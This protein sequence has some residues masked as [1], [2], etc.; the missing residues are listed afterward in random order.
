VKKSFHPIAWLLPGEAGLISP[1]YTLLI[2]S[3][4]AGLTFILPFFFENVQGRSTDI[5]GLLLAIPS[6]A[7]IVVGPISG[8]LSDRYGTRLPMICAATITTLSLYLLAHFTPGTSLIFAIGTILFLGIGI[9]IYFP[10][11]MSQILGAAPRDCEGVASG[12]MIT[13]RYIGGMVGIAIFGTVATAVPAGIAAG[14]H[15]L[16]LPPAVLSEG[17]TAAFTLGM[18]FCIVAAVISAAISD[19]RKS[20]NKESPQ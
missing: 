2:T 17:Y 18:I 7:I 9:G 16:S 10:S 11:N 3:V 19:K 13:T 20:L 4:L 1:A 6:V 8:A 14:R 12:V 5:A 15:L